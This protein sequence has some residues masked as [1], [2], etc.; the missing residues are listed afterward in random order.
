RQPGAGSGRPPVPR[1]V[2]AAV[3]PRLPD[4][5]LQE[6]LRDGAGALAPRGSA[7]RC[8]SVRRTAGR[9]AVRR[10]IRPRHHRRISRR[11]RARSRRAGAA[12]SG[13]RQHAGRTA[14][15]RAAASQ[16]R[17]E[18]LPRADRIPAAHRRNA[19][20]RRVAADGAGGSVRREL[21][22]RSARRYG[23]L[24]HWPRALAPPLERDSRESAARR[25]GAG[26]VIMAPI[27]ELHG[28][29]KHFRHN[30]TMRRFVALDGLELQVA[31]GELLGLIGPNGAGKT[32][33]FKVI[34]GL[35]HASGGAVLFRG[36]PLTTASRAAIGFLPE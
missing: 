10:A 14:R 20:R 9:G 28:L 18:R 7:A 4:L 24:L 32:T 12:R 2:G 26:S 30:W 16:R 19:G 33:T 35:L 29:T 23:A 6:R 31:D 25:I 3:L 13:A 15:S 17:R 5:L 22:H 36:E 1:L 34:L 8:A 21:R 27:L 11:A